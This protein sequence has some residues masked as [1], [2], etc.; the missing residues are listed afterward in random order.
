MYDNGFGTPQD[1]K[2]AI[3]WYTKSAEQ[4]DADAQYNLGYMYA[5]G[6]GTPQD[7]V[8]AYMLWNIAAANGHEDAK[9]NMD[10]VAKK[11]ASEKIL[12]AQQLAKEWMEKY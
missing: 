6:Y 11:M 10:I 8:M 3:K 2:A 5:N 7:H 12:E 4:G 1:Y 9:T